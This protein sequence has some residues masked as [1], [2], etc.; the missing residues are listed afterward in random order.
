VTDP[1]ATETRD[2]MLTLFNS[3]DDARADKANRDFM[4]YLLSHVWVIPTPVQKV[5][6][7]WWPWV[8]NYHG[9]LSVGI[10]N[11]YA[12]NMYI[13]IDQDLKKQMGK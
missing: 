10:I 13:W 11:E 9:E 5:V 12:E 8:K 1:K 2:K 6:T 4:P 3:G 7:Y